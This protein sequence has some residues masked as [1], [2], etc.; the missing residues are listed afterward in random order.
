MFEIGDHPVIQNLMQTGYPDGKE[1]EEILCPICGEDSEFFYTD[2]HR[3][4]V[5][6]E[7]CLTMRH[8]YEFDAEELK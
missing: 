8:Y 3:Q 5:G 4:I 7:R 2:K 1:P 6:C